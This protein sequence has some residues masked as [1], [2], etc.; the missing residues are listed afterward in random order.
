MKKNDHI[1]LYIYIYQ[2]HIRGNCQGVSKYTYLPCINIYDVENAR[3]KCPDPKYKDGQPGAG[4]A[5]LY[6]QK[7]YTRTYVVNG[8]GGPAPQ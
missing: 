2:Q 8:Y 6:E 3:S 1:H 5:D 4:G 7:E